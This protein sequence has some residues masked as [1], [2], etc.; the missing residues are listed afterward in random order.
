MRALISL[1]S[2]DTAG[3]NSS[4]NLSSIIENLR[5]QGF[6][7][8]AVVP[9]NAEI[10]STRA[11]EIVNAAQ[12][13]G[14]QVVNGVF[15]STNPNMLSPTS[16]RSISQEFADA[17]I[18]GDR[19]A[20]SLN[21]GIE[22]ALAGANLSSTALTNAV[23]SV[24][25]NP[26]LLDPRTLSDTGLAEGSRIFSG[27][28]DQ[29]TETLRNIGGRTFVVP[30]NPLGGITETASGTTQA[31][32]PP[33]TQN[34]LQSV[35][36]VRPWVPIRPNED[37]YNFLTGRKVFSEAGDGPPGNGGGSGPGLGGGTRNIRGV[38][39]TSPPQIGPRQ[40]VRSVS[41]TQPSNSG[42]YG[43]TN[44]EEG[45]FVSDSGEQYTQSDIDSIEALRS[46]NTDLGGGEARAR[47]TPGERA[48]ATEQGYIN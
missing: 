25:G 36:T 9:P 39:G 41:T 23:S 32:A 30:R 40:N 44:A 3:T 5:G 17:T 43:Q 38:R 6:T 47:L 18:I 2:E 28:Y 29:A 42:A 7:E 10:N 13:A 20:V 21:G 11:N 37:R 45:R 4:E 26:D 35:S 1:G 12:S 48:Y 8:F 14:A 19:N 34:R 22:S 27:A 46:F 16:V 24:V 33:P 31:S 15:D